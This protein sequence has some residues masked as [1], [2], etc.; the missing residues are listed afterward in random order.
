MITVL[1]CCKCSLQK[2]EQLQ[3][4]IVNVSLKLKD[5]VAYY[6]DQ[7]AHVSMFALEL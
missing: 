1:I 7:L 2:E 5:Q 3:K 4:E 6:E